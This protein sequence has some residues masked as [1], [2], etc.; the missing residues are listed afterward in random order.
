MVKKVKML[1]KPKFD[2][3]KLN[4]LYNEAKRGAEE[5]SGDNKKDDDKEVENLLKK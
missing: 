4:E 2:I 3:T 5:K 1:K